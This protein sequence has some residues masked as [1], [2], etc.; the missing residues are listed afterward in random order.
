ME[1]LLY[2]RY[3]QGEVIAGLANGTLAFFTHSSGV[4]LRFSL[5]GCVF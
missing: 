3:S 1:F 5:L 4:C 2:V